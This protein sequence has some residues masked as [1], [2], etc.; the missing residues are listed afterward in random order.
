MR[1]IRLLIR[2]K[3]QSHY[4]ISRCLSLIILSLCVLSFSG[5]GILKAADTDADQGE[6]SE[7]F[8]ISEYGET[9][10][11]GVFQG[12]TDS[13]GDAV[14][15]AATDNDASGEGDKSG[16]SGTA[17]G[18]DASVSDVL[19]GDGSESFA[20]QSGAELK[21]YST[22]ADIAADIIS[23]DM[24]EY[25][26]V[27]AI[28]DYIVI[29]VD[30][31]YDNLLADTV[32]ESSYTA[33]GALLTGRAV[34]EG[35]ARAFD[36][37][38]EYAGV[39]SLFVHGTADNGKQVQSHAWNQVKI[40]GIWYNIDV[41]WDDP[42]IDESD[43]LTL[44]NVFYTYFL[45]PDEGFRSSHFPESDCH[46]CTDDRYVQNN[47]LLTIEPYLGEI[48]TFVDSP[49]DSLEVI[50]NYLSSEIYDFQII[51][52]STESEAPAKSEE[53]FSNVYTAMDTLKVY[54]EYSASTIYGIS[55]Y[56]IVTVSVKPQ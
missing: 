5:C 22:V 30:Y 47:R 16:V 20:G 38:C 7:T 39:E 26:K 42:I 41:T 48:Y 50:M 13:D 36:E 2:V 19:A 21:T 31:D 43:N 28:H 1:F 46:E 29:N 37:L 15:D 17:S 56:A 25:D 12:W 33:E 23:D 55:D 54:G 44:N 40:N 8:D 3:K 49:E 32:P 45:V 34:C 14:D 53:I 18:N 6:L 35:Y 10:P 4:N 52:D 51:M 24:T 9:A 27:K 11:D